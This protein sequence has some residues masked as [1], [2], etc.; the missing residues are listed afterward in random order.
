VVWCLVK[1]NESHGTVIQPKMELPKIFLSHFDWH[2]IWSIYQIHRC[3][4]QHSLFSTHTVFYSLLCSF[5]HSL[6]PFFSLS[7]STSLWPIPQSVFTC[8]CLIQNYIVLNDH[9]HW[10]NTF[11]QTFIPYLGFALN[12]EDSTF[13]KKSPLKLN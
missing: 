4:F 6:N 13:I 11:Q 3:L 5:S 10:I 1:G 12:T 2:F 9:Y 7:I 8:L